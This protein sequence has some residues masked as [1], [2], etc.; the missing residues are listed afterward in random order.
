MENLSTPEGC[1]AHPLRRFWQRFQ[2]L[3][4]HL[5]AAKAKTLN[6]CILLKKKIEIIP[7]V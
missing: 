2:R 5:T 6:R 1:Q 3:R 4:G 7:K